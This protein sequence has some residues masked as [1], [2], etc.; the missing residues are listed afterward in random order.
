M[1]GADGYL[2]HEGLR[3]VLA[4][5]ARGNEYVQSSQPWALAKDPA[6]RDAL[7]GVLAAVIRQLARNA[8]LL[9]PFMPGK[10]QELWEQLGGP[11]R[12]ADA[13]FAAPIEV[14]GWRVKKGP[15]LF[16]KPAATASS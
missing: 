8:V 16:P 12:I 2:L 6:K 4:S 9:A 5:V 11:G 1:N 15:P 3:H 7:D 13:R 10:T 14:G